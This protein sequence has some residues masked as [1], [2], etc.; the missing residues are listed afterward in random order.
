MR[1]IALA[2][3]ALLLA[4]CTPS[5]ASH[6]PP[7]SPSPAATPTPAPASPS[8][9]PS[10]SPT[11]APLHIFVIVLENR[12]YA[13]EIANPYFRQLA[14]Q[15]AIATNYHGVSHPSLPNYLAMTSG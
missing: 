1:L 15:Y 3:S 14:A 4:A 9:S 11:G 8:P 10:P 2:T 12:S 13:Q 5:V 7:P 6:P